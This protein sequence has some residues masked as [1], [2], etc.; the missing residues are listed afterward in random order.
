M[1]MHKLVCTFNLIWSS[2]TLFINLLS[3]TFIL[4]LVEDEL[5]NFSVRLPS[6]DDL[7]EEKINDILR[8]FSNNK[9]EQKLLSEADAQACM[10]F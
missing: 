8:S 3:Y 7:Q 2:H 6:I 9:Q 5:S 1:L 10:Y 4:L